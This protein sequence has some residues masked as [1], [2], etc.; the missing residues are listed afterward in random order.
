[1]LQCNAAKVTEIP[2][3]KPK[4][5]KKK[6]LKEISHIRVVKFTDYQSA[7]YCGKTT[8]WQQQAKLKSHIRGVQRR[9]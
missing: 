9:I 4:L 7:L 6:I 2:K 1:M 5:K 3:N 8:E